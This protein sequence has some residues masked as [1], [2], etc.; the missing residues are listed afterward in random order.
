MTEANL[1]RLVSKLT[2][3][4]RAALKVDTFTYRSPSDT[5]VLPPE[6]DRVFRRVQDSA[7]Y[8]PNWQMGVCI[9]L[10]E[11]NN[12]L[13]WTVLGFLLRTIPFAAASIGQVHHAI[14][15]ASASP[16]GRPERVAIKVQLPNIAESV[17]SD[18]S[19]IRIL[20]TAGR[21]LPRGLLLEITLAVMKKELADECNYTLEATSM[22][23]FGSPKKRGGDASFKAQWEWEG[24]TD[25]VLV[26]EH[27]N[28]LSV[29]GDEVHHLPQ[30]ERNE[31]A[32]RSL[33]TRDP[34]W[35]IFL[36]DAKMG[37]VELVDFGA[38]RR[39]S[40]AFVDDWPRLLLAAARH[41]REGCLHWSSKLSYLTGKEND[42]MTNAHVESL[43][44]LATPFREDTPQPFAFGP[45]STWA[46]ITADIRERIPIMLRH[47][48]TPP[49]RETYSLNSG[50]FLLASRL[51][52]T[53][54]CKRLWDGVIDNYSFST[55]L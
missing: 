22:R 55:D 14:L 44:L 2:K 51:R 12:I 54:D 23:S 39:Y 21:L 7:H 47:R 13:P 26:V 19:D 53:V 9:A 18:L 50:A 5:H 31:I 28:G 17:T 35:S 15:A 40:A 1:T 29:G 52:V 36:W 45:G 33:P 43:Q 32:T 48:L 27:V 8:M 30:A 38:T 41:D 24:S 10:A 25:R 34:N 6:L 20:L 11:S 37:Q 42:A 4:R 46:G 3:M 49:P 16:T